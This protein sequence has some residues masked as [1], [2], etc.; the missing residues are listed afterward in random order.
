M[1]ITKH[2][3][4][5]LSNCPDSRDKPQLYN[6]NKLQQKQVGSLCTI[7][8]MSC[9]RTSVRAEQIIITC[10]QAPCRVRGECIYKTSYETF[11]LSHNYLAGSKYSGKCM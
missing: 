6:S 10:T 7:V 3:L 2:K 5:K 9:I 4:S 11:G 1:I 8:S